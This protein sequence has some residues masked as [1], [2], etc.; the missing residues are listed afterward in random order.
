MFHKRL[1]KE[2][3]ENQK[4]IWGMVLTQWVML[5]ANVVLMLQTATFIAGMVRGENLQNQSIRLLVTLAVVGVVRSLMSLLNSKLSFEASKQVKAR[6][7]TM[8]YEKM[9]RLGSSYKEYFQTSE[10]VQITTEGV[11]QLE[12]YFGKYMPQFFYSM[13]A[14]V[15]LFVIVGTMSLKVA[16]VLLICVPLIPLSIVAVQKFAKKM[17]AKYW[18]T[19]TEMG[20]SFLECLQG[21]TTLKIYQAD[22]RYAKRMDEEAEK[23]RK[24]TMR[25][26]IMQLNSISIMDLVA[27]GGA[28]VGIIL[29]I[30]EYQKGVI[31]LAQCFFII[32]IS[33]E[34][35]LPL[36][37]LGSF[38]HIAMNGNAA[39]DKIFRLV[40][41][42]EDQG[43]KSAQ[44]EGESDE[45]AFS[46]VSFSYEAKKKVLEGI[47]FRAGHG[48]TA[49]V[50]ESGCGKSTTTLLLMGDRRADEGQIFI[51]DMP[52]D[53]MDLKALRRKITRIRHDSY[54][55]AGTIR[56]NLLMGKEDATET[57]MKEALREVNLLDFVEK[58]GG[59]DFVLLEKASNLSG[60]Q[61]Q[62][63]SLARALLHD[64]PI[65]IFDE[66][67]SNV[68]VESENDIMAVV[69]KLA[70][71]KTVLLISHRLANV[72]SADQIYVLKDGMIVEKGQHEALCKEDG[73]YHRL[74]RQQ[75][76]LEQFGKGAVAN[77]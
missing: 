42:E 44:M 22:E 74:F 29:S 41:L 46:N 59:L 56:E 6:L 60:G 71:T 38:F 27:Y 10:V 77:E 14:P 49:L 72:V 48:L 39:A 24:V 9:M 12:I 57:Q 7:R 55:F 47:S 65:Y 21:L 53:K 20:D 17:L 4:N 62:R 45:I 66:A 33:A 13:L 2:F 32:M 69:R 18:G 5:I 30:L 54:L 28:A 76:A 8:V 40:D 58:S 43:E 50:G 70:K 73:Y 63:L 19:Y 26:L 51:G 36:R 75:S 1:I 52:I 37:L 23:F 64:T 67:T 31:G 68:D 16:V 34:F 15:T 25:V 35:F 61:K 11:E 3:R